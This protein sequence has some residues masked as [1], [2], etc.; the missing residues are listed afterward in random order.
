[1]ADVNRTQCPGCGSSLPDDG[2]SDAASCDYCGAVIRFDRELPARVAL[3]EERTQLVDWLVAQE[4][5]WE[6]RVNRARNPEAVDVAL[7]LAGGCGTALTIAIVGSTVGRTLTAKPGSAWP[8]LFGCSFWLVLV[9]VPAILYLLR[10][11]LRLRLAAKVMRERDASLE[12]LRE[13]IAAID[14]RLARP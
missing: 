9:A 13:K 1:V 7:P 14:E 5:D 11:R 2:I 6:N 8:F 12:P 4:Q 3:Q 10:R